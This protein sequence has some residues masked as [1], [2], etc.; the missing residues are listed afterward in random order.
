MIMESPEATAAP[1]APDPPM[2]WRRA[3]E[4]GRL[5]RLDLWKRFAD[6][7]QLIAQH[8]AAL[9]GTEIA[10]FVLEPSG[11]SV[12]LANGLSFTLDPTAL[13]EAPNVI[14]AQGGYETFEKALILRL[15]RGARTVFDIGANI[16]WHSLHIAQQ[17]P[18]AR[19]YAFE[20]VPTTH[21]RLR[22]NLARNDAGAR[23]T[24]IADGL[25]D[26]EGVFDMFVPA[27]SGSPAASLNE[28]H[29]A[30]GSHRT[31]CR[32]TT[33]DDFVRAQGVETLDL[34]KCD[35]E[36]AELRVLAGGKTTLAR[37]RPALIIELLR[38]WAAAF[39]YHPND[40]I[41]LLG[42]LGYVCYGVGDH[43]LT[44]I[45]RVTEDTRETNY[46]FLLPERHPPVDVLLAGL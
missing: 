26:R 46:L 4:C 15:A 23:V 35:V 42:G 1:D 28:L 38:K 11:L 9:A 43:A 40:V 13:R 5:D 25:S 31:P 22:S 12:T 7:H 8:A 33:L 14:I 36:G 10:A 19:V 32:F 18:K 39:G 41:D 6:R 44:P 17:E 2:A 29:P 20:P 37:F 34:L 30:E 45:S 27:T 21:A 24:A 16:G 3:F